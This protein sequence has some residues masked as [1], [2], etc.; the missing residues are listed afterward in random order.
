M[1]TYPGTCHT[2]TQVSAHCESSVRTCCQ[3]STMGAW[4]AH[5]PHRVR[6]AHLG[7]EDLTVGVQRVALQ[8]LLPWRS[9]RLRGLSLSA[10][11]QHCTTNTLS[12]TAL[13]VQEDVP[14]SRCNVR[15]S[16][17]ASEHS[18]EWGARLVK[19]GLAL[20][21]RRVRGLPDRR[22]NFLQTALQ[23]LRNW[24]ARPCQSNAA[25][26]HAARKVK[27]TEGLQVQ[28]RWLCA[29]H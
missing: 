24:L 9:S 4:A 6:H 20:L 5:A 28:L 7:A 23:T 21:D 15:Q 14:A 10:I 1:A 3:T 25:R 8:D 22:L 27:R 18:P 12:S 16:S 2:G 13:S 11:V 29:R 26:K 19:L 17:L